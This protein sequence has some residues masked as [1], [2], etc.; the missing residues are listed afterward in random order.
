M[1]IGSML[2]SNSLMAMSI[3]LD[4]CCDGSTRMGAPMEI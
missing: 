2:L 1:V 3:G 4:S